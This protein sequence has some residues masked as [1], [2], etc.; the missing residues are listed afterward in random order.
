MAE[1][2][3]VGPLGGEAARRLGFDTLAGPTVTRFE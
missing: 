1:Q 3:L 2:V